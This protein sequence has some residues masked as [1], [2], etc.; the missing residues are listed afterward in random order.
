MVA[1]HRELSVI[2]KVHRV[3]CGHCGHCPQRFAGMGFPGLGNAGM[4]FAGMGFW[5]CRHRIWAGGPRMG[6]CWEGEGLRGEK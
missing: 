5:G 4:G 6:T 1:D 2:S 3:A